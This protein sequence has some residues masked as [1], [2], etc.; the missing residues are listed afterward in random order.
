MNTTEAL[1]LKGHDYAAGACVCTQMLIQKS[2]S[3]NN[4]GHSSIKSTENGPKSK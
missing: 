3:H 2:F 1:A 4:G